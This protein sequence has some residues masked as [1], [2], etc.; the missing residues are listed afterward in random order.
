MYIT[1]VIIMNECTNEE[2]L[3]IKLVFFF[4]SCLS[5]GNATVVFT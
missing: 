3:E 5:Y 2:S 1:N 4:N